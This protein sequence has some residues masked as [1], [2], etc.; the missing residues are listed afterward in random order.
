MSQVNLLLRREVAEGQA[1]LRLLPDL[2]ELFVEGGGEA[3]ATI[4]TAKMHDYLHLT[5]AGYLLLQRH[6]IPVLEEIF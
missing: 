2:T 4:E 6:L 5:G 1:R 3:E